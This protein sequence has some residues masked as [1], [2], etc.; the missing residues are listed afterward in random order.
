A[1]RPGSDIATRAT[2]WLE[3]RDRDRPFFLWLHF[4][5]PHFPYDPPPDALARASGDPYLGEVAAMDSAIGTV[6]AALEAEGLYENPLIGA[7]A[8]P[9]EGRGRHGEETHGAFVFD[10]T[11]RIPMLARLPGGT[12]AG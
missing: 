3:Q 9:G 1:S 8:D 7:C 11:L 6:L 4:Y 10:S 5:D 2:A 12:R